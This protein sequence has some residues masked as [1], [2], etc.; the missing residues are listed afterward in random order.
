MPFFVSL[1]LTLRGSSSSQGS[2][3]WWP[4][5]LLAQDGSTDW[6]TLSSNCSRGMVCCDHER[7]DPLMGLG[8]EEWASHTQVCQFL[9]EDLGGIYIVTALTLYIDFGTQRM[10][11]GITV[12]PSWKVP[13]RTQSFRQRKTHFSFNGPSLGVVPKSHVVLRLMVLSNV[14]FLQPPP[15]APRGCSGQQRERG[16]RGILTGPYGSMAK[17]VVGRWWVGMETAIGSL[18]FR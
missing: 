3:S 17:G 1:S 7:C 6:H 14:I 15:P 4:L 8:L 13:Q 18:H 9:L 12:D 10:Y 16:P 5:L 11:L 2:L